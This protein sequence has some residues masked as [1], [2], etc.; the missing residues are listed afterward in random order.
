MSIVFGF[1]AEFFGLFSVHIQLCIRRM[2]FAFMYPERR[3]K[4]QKGLCRGGSVPEFIG[5]IRYF[6]FHY[7]PPALPV[8]QMG[9]FGRPGV[10]K[11]K[12]E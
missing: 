5:F 9:A 10:P 7:A 4:L 1:I 6:D 3:K 2:T 11:D 8:Q 12:N